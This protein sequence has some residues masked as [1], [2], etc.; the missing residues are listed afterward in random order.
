MLPLLAALLL[1]GTTPLAGM[2]PTSDVSQN[3]VKA[4]GSTTPRALKDRWSDVVNVKDYGAKGD[5]VTDD[6]AAIQA[7]LTAAGAKAGGGVNPGATVAIPAGLYLVSSTLEVPNNVS[8]AMD[9]ATTL[10]AT[11][12]MPALL[13]TELSGANPIRFGTISGGTLDANRLADDALQIRRAA[14]VQVRDLVIQH[15]K[16]NGLHAGPDTI[17]Y[18][19][20]LW[21]YNV[22]V[23]QTWGDNTIVA[24]SVGFH[25]ESSFGD[26]SLVNCKAT[27]VETGFLTESS[28]NRLVSCHAWSNGMVV[29][30]DDNGN[31][32]TYIAC[33]AD[34]PTQSG[35]R[36][37]ANRYNHRFIG[38]RVFNNS[39]YGVDGTVN[40]F[41]FQHLDAP[42]AT[43]VG[44]FFSGGTPSIRL[45]RD[46]SAADPS[47]LIVIGSQWVNVLNKTF[48]YSSALGPVTASVAE[49][50]GDLT[51]RTLVSVDTAA[52]SSTGRYYLR[53][54]GK[55]RWSLGN[56][57]TAET[58]SNAGS[59]FVI[60][61]Y[62]DAGN[63]LA[64]PLWFRRSDRVLLLDGKVKIGSSGTPISASIRLASSIDLASIAANTCSDTTMTVT[65]AATAAECVVGM[66]IAP[67][68]GL[69]WGCYVSAAD[70]VKLRVC[71]ATTAPI[72]PP[73]QTYSVRVF[74]P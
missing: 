47:A 49:T 67:Q 35:F 48:G 14:G 9:P 29:S 34:T 22:F 25:L 13:R 3:R 50:K 62:D 37:R 12:S 53:V 57:G 56:N 66:P 55:N 16:V 61:A 52:P 31:G 15:V 74:N 19:N 36:V 6:T 70:T 7:A 72:D 46:I 32:N 38:C 69:N 10:R 1:A 68:S 71:N 45:G 40:G 27:G 59:D 63:W 18:S 60:D 30:F 2:S 58:G 51:A 44:T 21:A 28:S 11:A 64:T 42:Y 8:I 5:G 24:G 23:Q 54:G 43:I 4:T 17:G 26:S 33:Y 65:G 73:L 20:E 39:T 41:E